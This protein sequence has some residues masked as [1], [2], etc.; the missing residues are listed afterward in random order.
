VLI[1]GERGRALKA[2]RL[3]DGLP[4][5]DAVWNRLNG[6]AAGTALPSRMSS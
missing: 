3:R 5:A 2:T 6:L 1:P 4:V